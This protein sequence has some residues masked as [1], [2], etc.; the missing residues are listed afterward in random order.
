MR[1]TFY[2]PFEGYIG[3]DT[4]FHIC[5]SRCFLIRRISATTLDFPENFSATASNSAKSFSARIRRSSSICCLVF[6]G[7]FETIRI[8]RVLNRWLNRLISSNCWVGG[9]CCASR[10]TLRTVTPLAILKSPKF[11]FQ[12]VIRGKVTLDTHTSKLAY[13]KYTPHSLPN[14]AKNLRLF[15]HANNMQNRPTNRNKNFR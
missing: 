1:L 8:G 9:N 7:G 14:Q 6:W 15:N 5:L 11:L 3:V 4:F 2:Y 13:L 10:S 12:K